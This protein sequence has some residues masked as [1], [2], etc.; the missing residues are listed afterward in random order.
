[1]FR[2][3]G[4]M[5][6]DFNLSWSKRIHS[7]LDNVDNLNPASIQH[8]GEHMLAVV[9]RFGNLSLEFPKIPRPI[10]FDFLG[11]TIVYYPTSWAIFI[12]LAVTLVFAGVISLGFQRNYLTLRG[13]AVGSLV[14]VLSL[15][16]VPLLLGMVQL[17]I[18]HPTPPVNTI[19]QATPQAGI[20]LVMIPAP[21]TQLTSA[22]IGDSLLSNSIR[23]GSAIL[24]LIATYLWYALFRKTNK[25]D[26]Y[27]LAI[28]AYLLLYAVACG[29]T[30]AFP[31]L[32][33]IFVWPL[34]AGLIAAL[35]W[36]PSSK[37]TPDRQAW[38]QF[39]GT[40]GAGVI[41][42]V[43]F[44]PG[45]LIA[46]LSIDIRMISLVPVFVAALLGFLAPNLEFLFRR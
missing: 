39:L 37:R 15:L 12:L 20:R 11:L 45:I 7:P 23:W 28:G 14:L 24:T 36:F 27:D 41:A 35:F 3:A 46:L 22:L 16:T 29:T 18:F 38:P 19:S 30:L 32:S 44:V 9:R 10:Y 42:V 40:L 5:G 21:A 33:Y 13:I 1:M 31:M 8:Q 25:V 17:V 4:W 34:L 26:R 2:K 6:F 43:M